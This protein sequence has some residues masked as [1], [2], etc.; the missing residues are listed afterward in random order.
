MITAWMIYGIG[1]LDSAKYFFGY[2][3]AIACML[4]IVLGVVCQDEGWKSDYDRNKRLKKIFFG[5]TVG[6]VLFLF[7][8]CFIPSSQLAASMYVV[9]A[10]ANNEKLQNIGKNTLNGLEKLT[11]QWM[12]ELVEGDKKNQSGDRI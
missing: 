12:Q 8:S 10:I 6:T 9:P 11:E 2:M 7:L 3:S 1:A 4:S 5:S